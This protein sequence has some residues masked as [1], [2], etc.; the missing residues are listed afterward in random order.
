MILKK[1]II[2]KVRRF[3]YFMSMLKCHHCLLH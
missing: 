2:H 1:I 3:L